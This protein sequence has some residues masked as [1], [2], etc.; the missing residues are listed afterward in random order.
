MRIAAVPVPHKPGQGGGGGGGGNDPKKKRKRALRIKA[1]ITNVV[2][3]D[4]IRVR[5]FGAKRKRVHYTVR[6]IGI[7]TPQTLRPGKRIECGGKQATSNMF[8]VGFTDPRDTDADGLM[9]VAG[10]KG[11][12]VTL[13]TD[14]TQDTFDG[15]DRLL[16]YAVT[17]AGTH[18]QVDQLTRGWA[19]VVLHKRRF[20]QYKRFT[21]AQAAAKGA[22]HGVWSN[23][24]GN[25]HKP[26]IG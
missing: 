11:R 24:G 12:R 3:G 15:Y 14:P 22:S 20:R 18:L 10:G 21:R 4:T 6:L 17:A 26:E 16:A 5:A 19:K 1:R 9:D 25:F 2:D 7:D 23:C 13:T 8:T